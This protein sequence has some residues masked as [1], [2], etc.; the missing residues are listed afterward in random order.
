[1]AIL[2]LGFLSGC[3]L[4]GLPSEAS[5]A[6]KRGVLDLSGWQFRS[7]G[8]VALNGDWD[9]FW[10]QLLDPGQVE[11]AL[12]PD[13]ER[14]QLP[15]TWNGYLVNGRQLSG[16]GCATFHLKVMLPS[17]S[18][19]LA[20]EIP[21]IRTAYKLWINGQEMGS[22]GTVGMD[23]QSSA[24]GYFPRVVYFHTEESAADITLQVSNF[25]HRSG[26]IWKQIWLGDAQKLTESYHRQLILDALFIGSLL[27]MGLYHLGLFLMRF[28]ESGA[29]YF[30][31][32]CLMSGV[33]AMFV[34]EGTVFLLLPHLPWLTGIR[35]EY[36]C[37][38]LSVPLIIMFFRGI[39]PQEFK[40]RYVRWIQWTGLLFALFVLCTP[41]SLFSY[42]IPV[43][44]AIT[45]AV[46]LFC[47]RCVVE[48]VRNKRDGA[49]YVLTGV[50]VYAVTVVIDMMYLNEYIAKG[51][52][53]MFG[54]FYC[55]FMISFIISL[56]SFRAFAAVETLSR[57]LRELNMG[58]E[59]RIKERTAELER[60]NRSLEKM[61]ED[62]GRLEKSRRHLLSNISHDLGTP[63]TLIQ[64]YVEALI[65]KVV[66]APEQQEKYLRLIL[67]RINGLNRLITDLFQLSKLEARQIDFAMQ[68]MGVEEFVQYYRDR[69][70][71]EVRNA[72]LTFSMQAHIQTSAAAGQ[73]YAVYIDI[74][75]IDQVLTN[76]I[77]NAIKHTPAG[78]SIALQILV[79]RASLVMKVQDNGSGIDPD[80]LSLHLR[81]L[82]QKGQVPQFRRRRQRAWARYR[83]GNRRIP[84]RTHLGGKQA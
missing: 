3:S 13:Q 29:L 26:G 66:V 65:D 42:T 49:L 15:H 21:T 67:T 55:I 10:E 4:R 14:I 51:N 25:D 36:L 62:L 70:E 74:D 23:K 33:R 59:H 81:P 75:R 2:L 82:L 50:I 76:I 84:R 6:A 78:G 53:S 57:Q 28:K 19:L 24:P 77:Y 39:Y 43:Y 41:A 46:C 16:F 64:G 35:I 9:F 47:I 8:N 63:M 37:Y 48:T 56:K 30:A 69:Y 32:F 7:D 31:L 20:L 72:G 60:S 54:L 12:K 22:S 11:A 83:Q 68:E 61:N 38:Y 17:D 1:M 34:G 5:A 80:E 73:K 58:L 79:D 18:G 40:L 71:I 52:I 44:Q 45:L 27:F